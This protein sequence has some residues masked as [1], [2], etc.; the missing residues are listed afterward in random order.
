MAKTTIIGDS[1]F[2]R[3]LPGGSAVRGGFGCIPRDP[4]VTPMRAVQMP[5]IPRSEWSARI[6]EKVATKSRL[7]DVRMTGNFGKPIPALDQGQAPYCWAHST[8]M[9]VMLRRAVN[10]L[11]YVPLSAYAVAATIKNGADEGG[12]GALS[13]DFISKRGVPSQAMWPQGSRDLSK[14]TA[15]CWSNAANHKVTDS[16]V[17][18]TAQVWD[19]TMTVEQV[20]TCLLLDEPVIGD[21]NWWG[22]SICLVDL[23]EISPGNF[24]L[25]FLN[26]WGDSFGT[27]GYAVLE[28]DKAIPNGASA[29]ETVTAS[30]A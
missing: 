22:H 4:A 6:E 19:A 12:W 26:S 23:V 18:L 20:A 14:G 24:G 16:W 1:N 17:D 7:S 29:V 8:T 13:L 10:N 28:G 5:T 11:P 25:G 3:Y 30:A 27:M 15:E 9:A 2:H 21:F